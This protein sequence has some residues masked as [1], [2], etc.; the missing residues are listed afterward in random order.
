LDAK[1]GD[2]ATGGNAD[3]YLVSWM[4]GGEPTWEPA[5]NLRSSEELIKKWQEGKRLELE[6]AVE[7][8]AQVKI[9]KELASRITLYLVESK[10]VGTTNQQDWRASS[11]VKPSLIMA[12]KSLSEYER[13]NRANFISKNLETLEGLNL[14]VSTIRKAPRNPP[15]QTK[16]TPIRQSKR[17]HHENHVYTVGDKVLAYWSKQSC[18]DASRGPQYP[19]HITCAN[20]DSTY[21]I[22]F[23]DDMGN[24]DSHI[25]GSDM[26]PML[27]T[28]QK[29]R[30]EKHTTNTPK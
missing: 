27:V 15:I 28:P 7:M 19:A 17:G 3:F 21:D 25:P 5:K 4:I 20:E 1:G 30:R 14:P 10:R 29:R 13:S 9:N 26:I 6:Q 11:L 23:D 18:R 8:A 16:S 22:K 12:W 24:I 2:A